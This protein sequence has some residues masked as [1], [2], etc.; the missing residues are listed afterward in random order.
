[1][2]PESSKPS[3]DR[4]ARGR[5]RSAAARLR[6]LAAARA[7]L[8][9]G[10]LAAVTMEELAARTGVGKP[11]IYR[12]WPNAKAVA[13]TALMQAPEDAAPARGGRSIAAELKRSLRALVATFS[14]RAGRNA[15]MLVASA[16]PDTELAK[17]FRHHVILKT[18]EEVRAILARAAGDAALRRGDVEVALDL[19]LAPVFFRLLLGHAP[20]DEAFADAVVDQA[21]AGLAVALAS[22]DTGRIPGRRGPR[23]RRT[24]SA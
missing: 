2:K 16:D 15:A 4:P 13:M 18:R 22:P 10:G 17:V 5:P 8:E 7:L 19:L 21:L 3:D 23:V 24:D 11:T 9:E 12:S 20:L 6:V 14:T 1:M